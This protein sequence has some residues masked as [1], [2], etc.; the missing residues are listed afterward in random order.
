M[1]DDDLDLDLENGK[2]K[3]GDIGGDDDEDLEDDDEDMDD[4]D[5]DMD[6][7]ED[8]KEEVETQTTY[9]TESGHE[10]VM[11]VVMPRSLKTNANDTATMS[12]SSS[13]T[14]SQSAAAA[15]AA[16]AAA[17]VASAG[18]TVTIEPVKMDRVGGGTT[19]RSTAGF[20][21]SNAIG[22][23]S[24]S[25]T[26]LTV[27]NSGTSNSSNSGDKLA[28]PPAANQIIWIPANHPPPPPLYAIKP[29]MSFT[30]VCARRSRSRSRSRSRNRAAMQSV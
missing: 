14:G 10:V 12:S 28:S 26:T 4:I 29:Q 20:L 24:L 23:G 17:I 25:S 13:A 3:S 19:T 27:V 15:A 2:Q 1:L 11:S 9:R 30:Q 16:A 7:L 5:D 22:T 6:D 21:T 18:S 8:D